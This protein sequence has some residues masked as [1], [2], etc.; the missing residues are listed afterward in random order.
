MYILRCP[1][2]SLKS[3]SLKQ[4]PRIGGELQCC[5]GGLNRQP[6]R[7]WGAAELRSAWSWADFGGM[8]QCRRGCQLLCGVWAEFAVLTEGHMVVP[9]SVFGFVGGL[10]CSWLA[11]G[12]VGAA[13]GLVCRGVQFAL[14]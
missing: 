11:V 13:H 5:P 7:G 3:A 10:Q 6:G 12:V 9:R 1:P 2:G 8:S 14:G 4:S